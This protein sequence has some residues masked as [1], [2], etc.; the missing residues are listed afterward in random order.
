MKRDVQSLSKLVLSA[1]ASDTTVAGGV[2]M[3]IRA[4]PTPSETV[5]NYSRSTIIILYINK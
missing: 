4:E 2:L 5:E 3:V 1:S